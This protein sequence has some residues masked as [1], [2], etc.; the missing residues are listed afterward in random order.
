ME[1]MLRF[2]DGQVPVYA[3]TGRYTTA[4]TIEL[5]LHAKTSGADG[6]LVIMP[7]YLIPHKRARYE[8]FFRVTKSCRIGVGDMP[9]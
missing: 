5:S 8:S 6:V 1:S 3:G 9:L 7:Y 2:I 4:E